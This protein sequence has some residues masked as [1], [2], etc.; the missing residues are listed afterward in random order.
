MPP[1]TPDCSCSNRWRPVP[2]A[3]GCAGG[4]GGG[5]SLRPES[6]LRCAAMTSSAS[7]RTIN[8]CSRSWPTRCTERTARGGRGNGGPMP[9]LMCVRLCTH[10]MTWHPSWWTLGL[11]HSWNCCPVGRV[12]DRLLQGAAVK[13]GELIATS[14][15]SSRTSSTML[16][17]VADEPKFAPA[18]SPLHPSSVVDVF[19]VRGRHG[20][21]KAR[22]CELRGD[23]LAGLIPGA[24]SDRGGARPVRAAGVEHVQV[25]A[26]PRSSCARDRSRRAR[27]L[28]HNVEPTERAVRLRAVL[29]HDEH[30]EPAGARV[31]WRRRS[32]RTR[33]RRSGH[34]GQHCRRGT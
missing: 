4:H 15:P 10:L 32:V 25:V 19:V 13:C 9:A 18:S 1:A 22:R 2:G 21:D 11:D 31:R 27:P 5:L 12:D 14:K 20:D 26:A 34:A 29:Q 7:D 8:R 23:A 3:V 33:G 24:A 28:S 30:V 6:G 16:T 17:C